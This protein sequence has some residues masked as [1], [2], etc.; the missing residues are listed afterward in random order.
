MW[1]PTE[2]R[3]VTAAPLLRILTAEGSPAQTLGTSG[4]RERLVLSWGLAGQSQGRGGTLSP[5]QAWHMG[6]ETL[7]MACYVPVEFCAGQSGQER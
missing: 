5:C 6:P 7:K 4:V 2:A 1:R 3:T